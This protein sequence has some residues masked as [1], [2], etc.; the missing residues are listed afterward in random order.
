MNNKQQ[1]ENFLNLAKEA[2]DQNRQRFEDFIKIANVHALL[3][4]A[5]KESR[6]EKAL[7]KIQRVVT[8][9]VVNHDNSSYIDRISDI[10]T[11]E[12]IGD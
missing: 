2:Q 5:D 8:H 4:T 11:D 6:A 1:A 12:M 9:A 3:A 10:I 7:T